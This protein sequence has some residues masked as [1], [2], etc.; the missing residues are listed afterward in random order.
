M[1]DFLNHVKSV[2]VADF[3]SSFVPFILVGR[4]IRSSP[5]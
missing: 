4:A 2:V 5:D 3:K 1:K